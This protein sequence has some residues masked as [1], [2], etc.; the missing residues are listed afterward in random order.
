[1]ENCAVRLCLQSQPEVLLSKLYLLKRRHKPLREPVVVQIVAT[2][3]KHFPKQF[4]KSHLQK[5][6]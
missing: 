3:S 1:M 5:K 6:S 4:G 2:D